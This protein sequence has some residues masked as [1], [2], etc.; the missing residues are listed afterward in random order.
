MHL[1]RFW[2]IK[3]DVHDLDNLIPNFYLNIDLG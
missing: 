1:A 2:N 3:F